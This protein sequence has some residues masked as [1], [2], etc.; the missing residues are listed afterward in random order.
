MNPGWGRMLGLW[1]DAAHPA[2]KGFPTAGHM[3][4]QWRDLVAGS[5]A[6]NL[7]RL[8]PGLQ[9]IVQPIDDWNRNYKLGALFEARV[10]RGRLV[11]STFDLASRLDERPAARQLR[12]SVLDYMASSAFAPG[13]ALEPGALDAVLFDSRIMHKLG[14]RASGWPDAANVVDG[15]PNTLSLV[16]GKGEGPRPQPPLTIAFAAPVPFDGLVL[17]PRQNHRDH[18]GDVREWRIEAS[19]DGEQWR[20]VRRVTL[21]STFD[22]QTV[23]FDAGIT[24][25][26]L[27]LTPLSGF[28]QDRASAL[29]DVAV[30]YTGPALP[31]EDRDIDYQRSR[32][33]SA[34]VDEAGM[35]ERKPRAA[36]PTR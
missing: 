16:P 21:G 10:G 34:D 12:R 27:R 32:S 23:R 11:V 36:K 35:E 2:L 31:D 29:A 9:P 22:P 14:A 1:V 15:D 8:P 7:D 5:R 19:D 4:W 30:L 26:W 25:R 24:A 6:M 13:T 3:D 20:D 28:G 17:M 18:E 33:T